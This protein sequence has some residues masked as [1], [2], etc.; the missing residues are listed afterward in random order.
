M[1]RRKRLR[2]RGN[3]VTLMMRVSVHPIKAAIWNGIQSGRITNGMNL[4]QIGAI[5]GGAPSPQ[6]VK[7]HLETMATMGAIDWVGG[8]YCFHTGKSQTHHAEA[9][10]QRSNDDSD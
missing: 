9:T 2:P 1:K 5:V 10:R 8:S 4:R 6:M 7:H 3:K